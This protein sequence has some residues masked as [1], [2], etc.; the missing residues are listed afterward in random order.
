M[1]K[2]VPAKFLICRFF[3]RMLKTLAY[4]SLPSASTISM[5]QFSKELGLKTFGC[6][7]QDQPQRSLMIRIHFDGLDFPD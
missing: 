7:L 4:F 5:F 2:E 6:T 1:D 3:Q